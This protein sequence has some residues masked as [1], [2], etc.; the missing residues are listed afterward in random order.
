MKKVRTLQDILDRLEAEDIDPRTV[1]VNP[2]A[3]S[4][5]SDSDDDDSDNQ[6]E[7]E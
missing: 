1:V 6:K 3:I 7:D 4:V 2:Q 5:V